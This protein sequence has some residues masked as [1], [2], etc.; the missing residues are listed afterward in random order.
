MCLMREL[1]MNIVNL[2]KVLQDL[3]SEYNVEHRIFYKKVM[4]ELKTGFTCHL[5]KKISIDGL[6]YRSEYDSSIIYCS[7]LCRNIRGW[8]G[9]VYSN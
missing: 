6:R 1:N 2:P 9:L 7:P 4:A 5:C 8:I 3:I